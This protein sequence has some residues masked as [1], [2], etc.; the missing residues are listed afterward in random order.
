MAE[1]TQPIL[2]RGQQI[3]GESEWQADQAKAHHAEDNPSIAGAPEAAPGPVSMISTAELTRRPS[4]LP[5]YAAENRALVALAQEM[6]SAPHNILQKLAETALTLCRAH[7]AGFSLLED[8]DRKKSFHWRAL[9]GQWSPHVGG[10]TPRDFGPCGT[11][12]DRNAA[13]LCSHPERDFPYLGEVSPLLDDGLL[14]PLYVDGEA[15]GTIWVISHDETCRFDAEDLRVMTNLGT[16]AGPAY[17]TLLSL[18]ATIKAHRDTT[19]LNELSARLTGTSD[20]P[21]ILYEILDGII[22]LQKADFGDVQL[23]D[24]ATGT[25]KIV[26]HRGLDQRFLDYFANV[27]AGDS[28]ACGLA[29]RSRARIIIEDVN[30]DPDFEPHRGI[31]AS[32]GFRAVQST[33]L[34]DRGSGKPLGMLSTHFREPHRPSEDELRL[35]DVYARQAADVVA[36]RLVERALRESEAKLSAI[37]NQ[38]PGGVGMFD[39]DGKFV[40]RGGPLSALWDDIIPSRDAGALRRWRSFDAKGGLLPPSQYPGARALH[41]ETVSPGLDLIHTADDGP[42]TWIRCSAA[43]FRNET[44]EIVGGVSILQN[45]DQEKRAEQR[46]HESEARLEAAVDL[47]KLGRYAWNPQTNELQWDDRLRA[48]WGLPAGAPIDY[49]V[50]RAGVHPNDLVRVEA[51][52][53]QCADPRGDGVYDI[54]YRVIGKT[55]GVQRWIATRGRTIFENNAPVSFYGVAR[56]ITD[57]KRIE[58]ALERRVEARTHELEEANRQLR[59]QIEQREI[60]E[61]EVQQLQ[62]LDAIGQITSGVAHD[63]NNLLSVVLTNARLLSYS[64]REPDDQDGI[65]LIR[66]AAERG[67]NLVGQLLAFSR[68]QRLE[69]QEVD[70][71]SKI[72]RMNGLLNATLGGTVQLRTALAPDLWPALVD[73]TQIEL[74]IL[75]LIINARDAMPSGGDLTLET[76]NAAVDGRVGGTEGPV[77][78]QYVVLLVSDTGTG[79]PDHVLPQIFEPFFTTKPPGKNSGLGL[80][81]VVGFA[82]QSGGGI[83]IETRVGK[84]TSVKVFL[85]RAE[86][87]RVDRE[88]FSPPNLS[89]GI[90]TTKTILVVDDDAAVLKTTLRLLS[91][92]GY[93]VVPALSG[94]E[95]LQLLDSHSEID[96]ILADYAMPTMSGAEL[97]K[98]IKTTRP[99]L[100]VI[101]VT[102][103]GNREVIEGFNETRILQKPYTEDELILRIRRAINER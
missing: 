44:G 39:R 2:A 40:L 49:E 89:S 17:K 52:I 96:L 7:S 29:L 48:M 50:W 60:A 5:D 38:L 56:D 35:S 51:A 75:N 11:V 94:G 57:R 46:L 14:I 23:Y 30:A 6:A 19:R 85:P 78:G 37:L 87:A 53:Q 76:R 90:E 86:V 26:A 36:S 25:L 55:D 45:V 70:L 98:T 71:N 28:S 64:L 97:A 67:V 18:D 101:L 21:S 99:A 3:L 63:F 79:I 91:S 8:G 83:G 16:F 41:G 81:Q 33:P 73:P 66:T 15:A 74:V 24:E 1:K 13:M 58:E 20:L 61:A 102:G 68:R 43:P 42:E 95:A 10:G 84:G 54:E 32:T 69:P 92:L 9:A 59:A 72:A 22:E 100:P 77:P 62:R 4:R 31:A 88:Q 34:L 80:A 103:Y 12:L 47:V 82:K 93:L 27:D 65:E